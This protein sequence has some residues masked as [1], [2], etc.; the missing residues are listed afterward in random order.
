MP[1][2]RHVTC[3]T[4]I[5]LPGVEGEA[6]LMQT[7]SR[8]V[9]GWGA[10]SMSASFAGK[11]RRVKALAPFP[12]CHGPM[13]GPRLGGSNGHP[14]HHSEPGSKLDKVYVAQQA[15]AEDGQGTEGS[16]NQ[17]QDLARA[18]VICAAGRGEGLLKRS[19]GLMLNFRGT[20]EAFLACRV[21][22]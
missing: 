4:M 16:L 22:C 1:V 8:A 14:S 19:T 9:A 6:P 17:G 15:S 20:L 7:A 18:H 21:S 11:L 2:R 12:S 10:L 5:V 13:V 3:S